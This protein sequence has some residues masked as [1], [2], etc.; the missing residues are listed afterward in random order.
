MAIVAQIDMVDGDRARA[1]ETARQAVAISRKTGIRFAGPLAMGALALA[2]DSEEERREV[3]SEGMAVLDQG[4]VGHNYLWFYRNAMEAL[5]VAGNNQGALSI[6]E[7]AE[8]YT[9][10][11]PLPWMELLV[12]R[13]RVLAA[14]AEGHN[15]DAT[16]A[17]ARN[18]F[19]LAAEKGFVSL[20]GLLK[21]KIAEIG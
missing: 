21:D 1:M 13:T 8:E 7:A 4:C 6:A 2:T 19:G 5:L 10:A 15:D 20:P 11:Q 3:I 9:S 18:I 16:L 14:L 17:E 12:R